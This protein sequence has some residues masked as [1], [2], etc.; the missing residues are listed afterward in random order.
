MGDQLCSGLVS[1]LQDRYERWFPK[2]K[3]TG[4]P[5]SITNDIKESDI[6]WNEFIYKLCKGD[7]VQ[8]RE[9]KK[10]D[11]FDFFDYIENKNG[12]R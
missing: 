12:G 2:R 8:M 6:F 5:T 10:M 3:G 4:D 9:I 11:V 7:A 1:R